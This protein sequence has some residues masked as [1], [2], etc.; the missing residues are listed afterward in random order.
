MM[1]FK[2]LLAEFLVTALAFSSVIPF[3]SQA[4]A[5]DV[6]E[7]TDP[8]IQQDL[9][10]TFRCVREGRNFATIAERGDRTTPPIVQWRTG[11]FGPDYT[12]QQRCQIVSDRLS[13]AVSEN[14]GR[15]TNLY[16]STGTLNR[17]PVVCY[18]NGGATRC[19]SNNLLFTLDRRNAQNPDAVLQDLLNFGVSGT[20]RPVLS[21]RPSGST[22]PQTRG[23][24]LQ[25]VVDEAFASGGRN[26]GG[27]V[28][29]PRPGTTN[30]GTR[31]I[32]PGNNGI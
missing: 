14:G 12:P 16:L 26:N 17:L 6:D 19:N 20:G 32:R 23:I 31:P 10:T 27:Q 4:Q 2:K 28:V 7:T 3:A 15:L 25:R 1:K 21:L 13:R 30:P 18:L 24:S 11:E 29:T 5:Q 9:S 22:A 8:A